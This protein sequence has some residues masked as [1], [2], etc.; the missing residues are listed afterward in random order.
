VRGRKLKSNREPTVSFDR[1]A[2]DWRY[3][4]STTSRDADDFGL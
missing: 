2:T 3:E 4:S 1:D